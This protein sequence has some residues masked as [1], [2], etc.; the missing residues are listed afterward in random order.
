[1]GRESTNVE[2]PIPPANS[3]LSVGNINGSNQEI[4]E[5]DRV[6]PAVEL[7]SHVEP[8]HTLLPKSRIVVAITT[9]A[10]VN[11]LSSI[12]NGL[13]AVGLPHM[14]QDINLPEYLIIW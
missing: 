10:G 5:L 9:L 13:V 4:F 2:S 11:F 14:V 8:A 12:T 3:I 6:H 1:M 7:I